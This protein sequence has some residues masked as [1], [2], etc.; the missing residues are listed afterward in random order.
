MKNKFKNCNAVLTID[1][2]KYSLTV[3]ISSYGAVCTNMCWI[4][5]FDVEAHCINK[6]E[7]FNWDSIDYIWKNLYLTVKSFI[8]DKKVTIDF[9]EIIQDIPVED[10]K[11]VYELLEF[12]IKLGFRKDE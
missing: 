12:G 3:L 11:Y 5:K 7:I 8:V 1:C 4:T 10:F 9:E 2:D 6:K